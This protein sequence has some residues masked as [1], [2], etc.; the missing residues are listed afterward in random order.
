MIRDAIGSSVRS[1]EVDP[2]G[3]IIRDVVPE[4]GPRG[5]GWAKGTLASD[6]RLRDRDRL[7]SPIW[8]RLRQGDRLHERL[9]KRDQ[10]DVEPQ[11]PAREAD[12]EHEREAARKPKDL[13]PEQQSDERGC[14]HDRAADRSF[15]DDDAE[16]E[17]S[18]RYGFG[19]EDSEADDEPEP[20][21]G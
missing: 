20:I 1:K 5:I 12:A 8:I 9:P 7:G 21:A 11:W 13:C 4:S 18:E 17:A 2:G 14:E 6:L 19:H 10:P 3:V 16:A 15:D